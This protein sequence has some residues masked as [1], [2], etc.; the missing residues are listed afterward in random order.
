MSTDRPTSTTR[1]KGLLS[2]FH[3][4]E[5]ERA[6]LRQYDPL[7]R[8]VMSNGLCV[9]LDAVKAHGLPTSKKP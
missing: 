4:T 6:I 5:E 9:I 1:S 8:G 3:L 7:K 2:Q